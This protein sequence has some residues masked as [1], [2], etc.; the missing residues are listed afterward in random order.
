MYVLS[1]GRG[2]GVHS[3]GLFWE[4][5]W[6]NIVFCFFY[7]IVVPLQNRLLNFFS[8]D[9]RKGIRA[10]DGPSV[11]DIHHMVTLTLTAQ[12]IQTLASVN[13]RLSRNHCISY[14]HMHACVNMFHNK[15]F[16]IKKV[17]WI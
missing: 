9:G 2:I 17:V 1:A 16:R 13:S 12:G 11:S 15:G 14:S 10:V 3:R 8:C 5:F 6:L 4:A 7:R